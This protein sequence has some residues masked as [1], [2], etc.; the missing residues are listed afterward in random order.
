IA[1]AAPGTAGIPGSRLYTDQGYALPANV[2]PGQS[3]TLTVA[4]LP[5]PTA[6]SYTLIYQMV[7][8]GVAFFPQYRDRS[9]SVSGG[10]QGSP[11]ASY[12]PNGQ[13]G[14][15]TVGQTAAYNINLTNT[16]TSTWLAGGSTPFHLRIAFAAPGT[17][18]IPGSRL[19][20]DQGYA[21]PANV[22]P[23]QSVTLIAGVLP[24][25][26]AG[27][28]TLIYQMVQEGIAFFPQYRDSSAAVTGPSGSSSPA[29]SVTAS[30]GPV[31]GGDAST[32]GAGTALKVTATGAERSAIVAWPAPAASDA[33]VTGYTVRVYAGSTST[34][35]KKV[36]A[37]SDIRT[38]TVKDLTDGMTYTF[39]V[40]PT[41]GSGSGLESDRSNPVTPPSPF[42][43]PTSVAQATQF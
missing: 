5:P 38:A 34:I 30:A 42:V 2:A 36:L 32:Q 14:T 13:P 9:V 37:G 20:T 21:L 35:V 3:V 1:F 10:A 19:Y 41:N 12:A 7:Q 26:T 8:E 33:P 22:A 31:A 27:S 43:D 16:G 4:V 39:T 18:G 11:A 15:F 23:G 40:Q 25:S 28:Y 6:G 29:I 24:P 17:A